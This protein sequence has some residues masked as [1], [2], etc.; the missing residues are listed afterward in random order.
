MKVAIL[1][2]YPQH[3]LANNLSCDSSPKN[4]I[5][6]WLVNLTDHL[7]K[8]KDIEIHVLSESFDIERNCEFTTKGVTFHFIRIP[9]KFRRSSLFMT[10]QII[11]RKIIKDLLPDVL[12]AHHAGEYAWIALNEPRPVVITI[13]G[14]YGAVAT[15][16]DSRFLS[17]YRFLGFIERLCLKKARNIIS[18]NP[19]V[20][21]YISRSFFGRTYEIENPVHEIFFSCDDQTDPNILLYVAVLS[22][23]KG[24]HNLIE[25]LAKIKSKK[26]RVCL[27]VVGF[28]PPDLEWYKKQVEDFIVEKGL[29]DNIL[30]L[31][32]KTEEEIVTELSK[33]NCLLLTSK[34]ET[35]PMVI[36]EAMAAGK[37]V[38][39]MDV[40][41]IRYM[42]QHGMTGFVVPSGET[43][44][45]ADR[46]VQ[47]L[48]NEQL[49]KSMGV[50]AREAARERFHPDIVARKTRA[51]YE[52]IITAGSGR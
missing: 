25:V 41:G 47:I 46:V 30:F 14:V 33:S 10:D 29:C 17:N 5:S 18:I 28:F 31:G 19:Y 9:P 27:H 6:T 45:M 40:G 36:S 20:S 4:G 2:N 42:I 49:R 43:Q 52:K 39:A 16:L 8:Q 51:V 22:P 35:A 7:T 11:F 12:H 44:T 21:E 15:S 38:V 3:I 24:L 26:Q 23:V 32:S 48:D 34:Q 50:A 37:P 1:G 13:H